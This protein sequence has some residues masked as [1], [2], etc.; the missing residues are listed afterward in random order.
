[1]TTNEAYQKYL[2]ELQANGTTDGV[3]TT[4]GRFVVNYNKSQNRV[5]EWLIERKNEDDNRYLQKIKV[6]DKPLTKGDST[7]TFDSFILPKDHFDFMDA[8]AFA[9]RGSCKEQ[10][11]FVE[12]FKGENL[13]VKLKDEDSKPS[14]KYRES[15]YILSKDSIIFFKDDFDFNKVLLTYYKYP[16]QIS[17]INPTFPDSQL[18]DVELEFDDKLTN[19]II[20][21]SAADQSLN[22]N[23]QKYQ[24][25]KQEVLSKL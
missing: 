6:V 24:A 11:F 2:I 3:Q 22:S 15:F 12:E 16:L 23:D 19:R 14:F 1:M 9:D 20:T 21:L 8:R 5:V 13:N 10:P 17:L 7:N 4:K 25:L 18:N